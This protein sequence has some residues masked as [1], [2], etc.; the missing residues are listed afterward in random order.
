MFSA[1]QSSFSPYRTDHTVVLPSSWPTCFRS[2]RYHGIFRR[3][4]S[5][6]AG[7]HISRLLSGNLR[8]RV[9]P[10]GGV[11]EKILAAKRA[12]I[13][14]LVLCEENRKDVE[15]ISKEYLTGLNFHYFQEVRDVLNYALI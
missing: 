2:E 15:E 7:F 4:C 3:R 8:G 10:I 1:L 5:C 12:G 13:T 6:F 9:L 14:D 11:K